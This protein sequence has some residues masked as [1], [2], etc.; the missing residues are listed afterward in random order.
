MKQD[1]PVEGAAPLSAVE[2]PAPSA[3]SPF[4]SVARDVAQVR[5]AARSH[6]RNAQHGSERGL[7]RGSEPSAERN[8]ST[9]DWRALLAGATPREVLARLVAKDTLAVRARVA[10]ALAERCYLLDA[11]AVYLRAVARI[12][13]FSTRYRGDPPLDVWLREQIDDALGDGLECGGACAEPERASAAADEGLASE[14]C[15]GAESARPSAFR[16]LAKPLGLDPERMRAVCAALNACTGA[17]RASFFALVLE[18]EDLDAAAARLA[19]SPTECARAARRA[20]EL[21]MAIA[22]R[23]TRASERPAR[24]EEP[25]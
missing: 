11:D 19:L 20:L 4:S 2:L 1:K 3:R 15:E 7:E 22:T 6:E 10:T 16:E 13:R 24:A 14:G 21:C 9:L 25:S 18:R 12:A 23:T 8:S 17:E 5:S